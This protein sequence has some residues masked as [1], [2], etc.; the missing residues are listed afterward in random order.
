MIQSK[1]EKKKDIHFG[2]NLSL[3]FIEEKYLTYT[4]TK[5]KYPKSQFC[6]F[7]FK[8]FCLLPKKECQFAHGFEDLN[9]N[10]FLLFV[11]D[12]KS[13]ENE[14]QKKLQKEYFYRFISNSE[15]FF[16][17]NLLEFQNENKNLF[18]KIFN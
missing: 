8:G 2:K 14:N 17:L 3:E 4:K 11:N 1:H 7:Y 18:K 12:K 5:I 10:N 6:F 13:F 9:Y 15:N 16:Y